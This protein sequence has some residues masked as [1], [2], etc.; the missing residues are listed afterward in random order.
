MAVFRVEKTRDY[1]VMA[2]HHLRNTELS[3]KAKGLLSLMLSLPENWDYTTKGLS[4]ICKDGID[5]INATVKELEAHGYITRRRIRNEKGQ[6]TTIEYTIFEQPQS[7]DTTDVPPKRENPILDKP[8]LEN[9]ILEN[10]ILEKPKQG[11]PIL[12][13]PHQLIT[14][15]SNTDLLNNDI[16]NPH[17][18]NPYPSSAGAK[19]KMGY[20]T[21]ACDRLEEVREL[22]LENIEYEYIKHNHDREQLNEIVDLMVE[23]L[24][25]TKDIINVSGDDYPAQ[26]VKEKL[27][28][29]NSLHIDYVFECLRKTTTYIRNIKRYLLATLFNAP[30]TIGTYYS[31]L[32][33]HDLYGD[34]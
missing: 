23:T 8:M 20:D 3:L 10:P 22:V 27:L 2:N 24:C 25:S 34:R 5:S 31:A 12:G 18:S 28:R 21:I 11:E 19:K 30:S 33:N 14:N 13:N 32:V 6:L 26:L 7:L 9:P 16:L 17:Q 15:K 1:T 29:I 4:C